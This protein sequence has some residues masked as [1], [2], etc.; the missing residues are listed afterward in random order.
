MN[1]LMARV[2]FAGISTA[3]NSTSQQSKRKPFWSSKLIAETLLRVV[4][5]YCSEMSLEP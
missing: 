3:V 5:V 2:A 4:R 1:Q